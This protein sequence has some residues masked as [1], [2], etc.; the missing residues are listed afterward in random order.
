MKLKKHLFI[1]FFIGLLLCTY[2]GVVEEY[3]IIMTCFLFVLDGHINM[4]RFKVKSRQGITFFILYY[5]LITIFGALIGNMEL[6][7]ILL[8][9]ITY[10]VLPIAIGRIVGLA[11]EDKSVI[12]CDFRNFIVLAALLGLAESFIKYNPLYRI[13]NI[14]AGEWI[15]SMNNTIRTYQ[16]SSLFLHYTYYASILLTGLV[17]VLIVPYKS[18]IL[19]VVLFAIM[20]EQLFATQSR[21]C[22][23]AYP[24][25]II[26]YLGLSGKVSF[27]RMSGSLV[28]VLGGL[29][30]VTLLIM[31]IKPSVISNLFTTISKRF[32]SLFIYG[33]ADGSLGQ[34]VGTLLNWPTYFGKN[35]FRGIFGTGFASI[36]PIFL[37]E[38]SYFQGYN[39]A[40]CQY[41]T[42]LIESGIVGLAIFLVSIISYIRK[43]NKNKQT[44]I[45]L[46]FLIIMVI[47]AIEC[48][49]YDMT[50]YFIIVPLFLSM[51]LCE[52]ENE[53]RKNKQL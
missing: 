18:K 14:S 19:N 43:N 27:R 51:R 52:E 45:V 44:N 10:V 16:P 36:K 8:F 24:I 39:T 32:S 3:C 47:Y 7:S 13:V 6:K 35:I 22:W 4:S 46:F 37:D 29:L 38:Y 40:D 1:I 31:L 23:I 33:L 34:R 21:I 20:T 25:M 15:V 9:L 41:V 11:G 49:T 50:T 26:S 5:F 17:I 28:K 48:I 2:R 53:S 12:L 42:F 30:G